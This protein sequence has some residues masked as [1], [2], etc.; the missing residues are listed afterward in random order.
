MINTELFMSAMH[1]KIMNQAL[2]I[3]AEEAFFLALPYSFSELKQEEKMALHNYVGTAIEQLGG[4]KTILTGAM[5]SYK[6]TDRAKYLYVKKMFDI[7]TEAASETATRATNEVDPEGDFD[8]ALSEA[9]F[10]EEE[11]KKF[12][13]AADS[14]E[15]ED[16]GKIVSEKV[17]A[18]IRSEQEAYDV[19]QNLNEQINDIVAET[20]ETEEDISKG[21]ESFYETALENNNPR[22]HVSLFSKLC[23]VAVEAMVTLHPEE[24]EE[25]ICEKTLHD[26]TFLFSL[27]SYRKEIGAMEA[28]ERLLT[29]D[30]KIINDG[31]MQ[32]SAMES[33]QNGSA[34]KAAFGVTATAYT[35]METLSTMN[36]HP[37]T[38]REIE[39]FINTNN[40][41]ASYIQ[42]AVESFISNSNKV[43]VELNAE[44]RGI[45]DV[46]ALKAR[47]SYYSDLESRVDSIGIASESFVQCKAAFM[48]NI[49]NAYRK[50][51]EKI[52]YLSKEKTARTSSEQVAF[53]QD[54]SAINRLYLLYGKRPTVSHMQIMT[55]EKGQS[56]TVSV[57]FMDAMESPLNHTTLQ[58]NGGSS[59]DY[60]TEL[61]NESK[62]KQNGRRVVYATKSGTRANL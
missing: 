26:T 28:I 11:F 25:D 38:N 20:A 16:V 43:F 29:V 53:E 14:L 13:T 46:E 4:A 19:E 45:N 36:L 55:D 35:L 49:A 42:G 60:V 37:L 62:F 5:E 18:T 6:D 39:K 56:T 32:E 30:A 50:I 22:H 33:I 40:T 3:I 47:R 17:V 31:V 21:V 54:L 51:D 23:E 34:T 27:D 2:T 61:V 57:D 9:N 58:L 8:Q 7:C 44:I 59:L 15:L 10:T 41:T 52:A 24:V 1:N 48:N 12:E